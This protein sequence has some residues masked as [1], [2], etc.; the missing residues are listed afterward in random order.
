MNYYTFWA[1]NNLIEGKWTELPQITP[2][3]VKT[4]RKM[5]KYFSG[6]L[7]KA[8]SC[9]PDFGGVEKHYVS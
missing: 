4:A 3:Q 6:D 1:T 8:I 5:K 9:F 2:S 7:E